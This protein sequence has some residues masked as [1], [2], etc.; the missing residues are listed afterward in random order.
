MISDADVAAFRDRGLLRLTAVADPAGLAAARTTVFDILS[1]AGLWTE[2]EGWTLAGADRPRWPAL[3]KAPAAFKDR[4][5]A[6]VLETLVPAGL[7]AGLDMLAGAKMGTAGGLHLPQLLWTLPNV[8]AWS[9]PAILWHTDVPRAE[10]PGCPGVQV[11][12]FLSPVAPGAGGTLVAAGSHRLL[13][14][15]GELRSKAIKARLRALP[16]FA[17][18]MDPAHP[19][20]P[21]TPGPLGEADG[22]PIEVV[23][24]T[25]A[26]GDLW[27]MDMR[28]LHTASPNASK[29][30]RLMMTWR[31]LREG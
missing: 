24:L 2:G 23:E 27:L 17:R 11:F 30:P 4:R 10:E 13:N 1:R 18:L 3:G 21:A 31:F 16:P 22:V 14:D 29:A 28:A 20:R 19:D 9:L 5:L 8:A 26:P 15:Q 7:I 25:G 12:S 6:A